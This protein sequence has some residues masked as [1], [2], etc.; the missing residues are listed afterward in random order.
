MV[1]SD[2]T[3]GLNMYICTYIY[4]DR[5]H[6]IAIQDARLYI[7]QLMQN[8]YLYNYI[9]RHARISQSMFNRRTMYG[10]LR[11]VS[12]PTMRL[13]ALSLLHH[14]STHTHTHTHTLLSPSLAFLLI[15]NADQ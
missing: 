15:I 6:G 5:Q 13:F 14:I 7:S 3:D 2:K 10:L 11:A 12:V 8:I 9:T 1:A 4:N